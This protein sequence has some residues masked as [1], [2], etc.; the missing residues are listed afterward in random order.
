MR[1]APSETTETS[2][3]VSA[4]ASESFAVPIRFAGLQR[5]LATS[6][7]SYLILLRQHRRTQSKRAWKWSPRL[8]E[9]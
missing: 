1:N 6:P 8:V 5:N 7:A 4:S 9:N 3:P 2:V